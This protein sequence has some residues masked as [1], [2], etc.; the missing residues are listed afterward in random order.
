MGQSRSAFPDARRRHWA[1]RPVAV[2]RLQPCPCRGRW[3]LRF[4]ALSRRQ[5]RHRACARQFA[6]G[7]DLR[8]GAWLA[9]PP[10]NGYYS[11]LNSS[12]AAVTGVAAARLFARSPHRR[13]RPMRP[14]PAI[15]RRP[16]RMNLT[17]TGRH[18]VTR[19]PHP[20]LWVCPPAGLTPRSPSPPPPPR[21]VTAPVSSQAVWLQAGDAAG[22]VLSVAAPGVG[23]AD[24]RRS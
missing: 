3:Q 2:C 13:R 15:S 6:D 21:P 10:P 4:E 5:L 23:L 19:P 7:A 1:G 22:A 14:R 24:A 20:G 16:R 8:A 17:A 9:S 11:T 12:P 18:R